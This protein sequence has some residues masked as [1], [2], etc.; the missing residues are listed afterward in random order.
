M[1]VLNLCGWQFQLPP[2][3]KTTDE[4][5]MQPTL[6]PYFLCYSPIQLIF[7]TDPKLKVERKKAPDIK[8]TFFNKIRGDRKT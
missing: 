8:T 1:N 3:N 7:A 4:P 2:D 5:N 6:K